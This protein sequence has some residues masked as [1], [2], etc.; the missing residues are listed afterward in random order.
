MPTTVAIKYQM[1]RSTAA[2]LHLLAG[3]NAL[4]GKHEE[5]FTYEGAAPSQRIIKSCT[6]GAVYKVLPEFFNNHMVEAEV[7]DTPPPL[8]HYIHLEDFRSI[9]PTRT[10]TDASLGTRLP[11]VLTARDVEENFQWTSRMA[12]VRSTLA[13][14]TL[15]EH[16]YRSIDGTTERTTEHILQIR[17]RRVHYI[18]HIAQ[19][20][21]VTYI[22]KRLLSLIIRDESA[23]ITLRTQA[24]I[25]KGRL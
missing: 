5:L 21:T 16:S 14:S 23:L 22:K 6:D 12:V 10:R 2:T 15:P 24:A 17:D 9:V 20:Y 4:E 18:S 19:E 8:P 13:F 11:L 1:P 3:N 7:E 25:I